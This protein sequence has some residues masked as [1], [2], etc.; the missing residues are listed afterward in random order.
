MLALTPELLKIWVPRI[1]RRS[2]A[3]E[4]SIARGSSRKIDRIEACQLGRG[5]RGEAMSNRT[6]REKMF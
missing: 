5:A 2:P 6:A 1:C 3:S 4:A